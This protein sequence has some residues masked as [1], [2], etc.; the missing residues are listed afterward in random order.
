GLEIEDY[1]DRGRASGNAVAPGYFDVLGAPLVRG[2][3]FTDADHSQSRRVAIVNE[4]FVSRYFPDSNPIGRTVGYTFGRPPVF[5]HE[6]VGVARDL[7]YDDLHAES[8]PAFYVPHR[9]FDVL[10][11][12]YFMVRSSIDP[13]ILRR[14]ID[15]LVQSQTSGLPVVD[16]ITVE[17]RIDRRLRPERLVASLSGA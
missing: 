7:R 15:D 12:A 17:D 11:N 14:S 9:Q 2:R 4:A 10:S 16:Y 8:G 1:D 3:D 6:I 13:A 5:S